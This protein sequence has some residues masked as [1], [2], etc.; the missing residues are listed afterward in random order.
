M[1]GLIGLRCDYSSE[2]G[3]YSDISIQMP[4]FPASFNNSAGKES[5]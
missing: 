4:K 3:G 2:D 1:K 5:D